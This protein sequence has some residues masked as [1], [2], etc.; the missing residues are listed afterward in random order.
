M[1]RENS[2][3]KS[4][5]TEPSDLEF[6]KPKTYW[7]EKF[8][9]GKKFASNAT[10]VVGTGTEITGSIVGGAT[11]AHWITKTIVS[12][13]P[14]D[15]TTKEIA[16][17]SY[18]TL[19]FVCPFLLYEGV[20][21]ARVQHRFYLESRRDQERYELESKHARDLTLEDGYG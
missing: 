7:Q 1:S 17:V 14:I 20:Q 11:L 21:A 19:A 6:R 12:Y 10:T 18:W 16:D 3:Y 13:L 9:Q 5:A 2:S 15:P 4:F 8:E